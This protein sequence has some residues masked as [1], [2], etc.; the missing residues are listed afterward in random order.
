MI[1]AEAARTKPGRSPA[2]PGD[3]FDYEAA[4]IACASGNDRAFRALYDREAPKMLGVAVRL[5]KRQ[6]LAEDAVHDAFVNIW[7]K[8]ATFDPKAGS[9]RGWIY[10]ILRNRALNMLRSEGRLDHKDEFETLAATAADDDP[11]AVVS[12]LSDAS[13]LRR[14]LEGLDPQRRSVLVLAYVHGLTQG[15]LAG[16]L[17]VPLGT[18]KSWIRRSLLS[19]KEC[20]G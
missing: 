7:N 5:L 15:E 2:R 16:R 14:C 13:A 17:G 11:E 8:A 19:L 18:M 12:G 6:S 4:L 3:D 1:G 10:T 20:M 9:A